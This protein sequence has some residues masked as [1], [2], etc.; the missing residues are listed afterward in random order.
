MAVVPTVLVQFMSTQ[1]SVERAEGRWYGGGSENFEANSTVARQVGALTAVT[2]NSPS[3][4]SDSLPDTLPDEVCIIVQKRTGNTG[5]AKRG[6]WFFCGLS[7][8]MQNA[9][10][11]DFQYRDDVKSFA[12]LLSTS[13]VVTT[14]FST[15]LNARHYDRKDNILMPITKCYALRTMGSRR[16]RRSPLRLTRL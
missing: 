15:T 9:G 10:E 3:D 7:E 16:D 14:G 8:Q 1:C 4:E 5:R 12:D 13:I 2:P 11:V 6:R